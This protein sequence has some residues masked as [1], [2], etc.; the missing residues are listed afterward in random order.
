[1]P[2]GKFDPSKLEKGEV[3][4]L[5]PAVAALVEE[6]TKEAEDDVRSSLVHFMWGMEHL[7]L[8]SQAAKLM[9]CSTK[10]YMKQ[11]LYHQALRDVERHSIHCPAHGIITTIHITGGRGSWERTPAP[12]TGYSSTG[13]FSDPAMGLINR[14]R[15]SER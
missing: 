7:E 1:M 13:I 11:A 2:R 12:I 9:G 3:Y 14:W 8:V 10:E 5:P 15:H 6:K 4:E